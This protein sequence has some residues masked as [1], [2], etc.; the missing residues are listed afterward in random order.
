MTPVQALKWVEDSMIPYYP[1]GDYKVNPALK[2]L[3]I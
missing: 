1:I 2:E 3:K